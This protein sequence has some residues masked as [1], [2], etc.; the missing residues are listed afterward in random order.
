[1]DLAV[2]NKAAIDLSVSPQSVDAL[3]SC[4]SRLHL[5]S[6]KF[7]IIRT[8]GI[9][10]CQFTV[11]VDLAVSNKAAIDLSV[12]P[13]VKFSSDKYPSLKLVTQRERNKHINVAVIIIL[14]ID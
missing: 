8:V 6:Q 2:S 3:V 12:H 9:G 14:F 7:I 13:S 5:I 4:L 11:C 1:V 10:K